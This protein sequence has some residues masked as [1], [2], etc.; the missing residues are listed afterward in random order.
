MTNLDKL[1]QVIK[2]MKAGTPV[3]FFDV[4]TTGLNASEDRIVQLAAFKTTYKAGVLLVEEKLDMYIDPEMEMPQLAT[5][6]NGITNDMLRGKPKEKEAAKKISDFF[7]T[8]P[9]V[10]GYNSI[11]FDQPFLDNTFMRT[12]N[13]HFTPTIHMDVMSMAK[14]IWP[15]LSSYRL[16]KV[17]HEAGCDVGLDF[18]NASDDVIATI[19]CFK[20]LSN[21]L[22]RRSGKT[23]NK[24]NVK[25]I[26]YWK[27]RNHTQERFYVNAEGVFSKIY[28]NI[29]HH[30]F[31]I[32][33]E[34]IGKYDTEQLMQDILQMNKCKNEKELIASLRATT[35]TA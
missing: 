15:K 12:M 33:D 5:A 2:L 10:A 20:I 9:V 24:I 21:E 4:E 6:A 17:S 27:G 8:A 22:V 26:R 3:I 13:T 25:S 23:Q 35:K 29:Y 18:H 34:L 14:E 7:G 28:Y 11:A 19:R 30:T 31:V 32:P 1:K 16:D